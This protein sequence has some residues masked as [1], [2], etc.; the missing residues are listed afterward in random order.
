M[1]NGINPFKKGL[2]ENNFYKSDDFAQ[3]MSRM[4][5]LKNIKGIGFFTGVPDTGK[6]YTLRCFVNSLNPN[7]YKIIY[8]T[9]NR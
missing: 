8:I 3:A 7:L 4:E 1:E 5:H 9:L 6:T 2:S